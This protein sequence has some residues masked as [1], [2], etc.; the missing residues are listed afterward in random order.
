M[1]NPVKIIIVEDEL[2]AAESLAFDLK[3]SGYEVIDIVDCGEEA[4]VK[5][6][7]IKPDLML[8]DIMLGGAVDGILASQKI[9]SQLQIPIVFLTAYADEETLEKAKKTQPYG[10]LIKPYKLQELKATIEIA[11]QK[12]QDDRLIMEAMAWENARMY[13]SVQT[14]MAERQA[15]EAKVQT[16]IA[17]RQALEAKLKT[18]LTEKE[19]LLQEVHHRVNNNLN[20]IASL[21]DLQ[22][23][24]IADEKVLSLLTESQQRIQTMALLHQQLYKSPDLTQI[25]FAEYV[26][27]VVD[28]VLTYY[29]DYEPVQQISCAIDILP[30]TLNLETALPCG[31]LIDELVTNCFKHA[32][33]EAQSGE[34]RISLSQKDDRL[35][36]LVVSD[37][38]VGFP[39]ELDWKNSQSLGLSL[40]QLLAEQ[41]DAN[42]SLEP[43][44]SGTTFHLTFW[45]LY[46][47]KRI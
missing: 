14:E 19:V 13:A 34:V 40:V 38:G 28:K 47:C 27:A 18:S 23:S 11:L 24:Y 25:D 43:T 36:H 4:F 20:A 15:L 45:E 16:E 35:Y 2:I 37:N 5:A 17:E 30:I 9:S 21:F 6:S 1:K 3:K 10:Y 42:I 41:L 26:Q 33:P 29:Y 7:Q 31:L 8:M 46:Y 32:F 12:W 44:A 39:P 22:S